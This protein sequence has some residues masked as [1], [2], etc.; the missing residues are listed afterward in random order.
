MVF[1]NAGENNSFFNFTQ[2]HFIM[3]LYIEQTGFQRKTCKIIIL[4]AKLKA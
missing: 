3:L 4:F 2:G 1:F